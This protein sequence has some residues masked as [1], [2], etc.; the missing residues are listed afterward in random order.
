MMFRGLLVAGLLSC[1]TANAGDVGDVGQALAKRSVCLACHQVDT[2][3]V[4]PS[5]R[6]IGV[7]YAG[8]E[9]AKEYLAERIRGGSRGVWG[10]I[11]M[12]A[13]RQVD[14]ETALKLA[15]WILSLAPSTEV[16]GSLDSPAAGV[17]L[18]DPAEDVSAPAPAA[19]EPALP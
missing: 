11:P 3:R 4:G 14:T 6:D 15:E 12:P 10:A 2:K 19:G 16:P 1:G 17:P 18:I 13:Q 8:N 7:R 5:F 9:Q